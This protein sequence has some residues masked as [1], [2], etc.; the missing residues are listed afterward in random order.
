MDICIK[1]LLCLGQ[2]SN[3]DCNVGVSQVKWIRRDSGLG[4]GP[5]KYQNS[6]LTFTGRVHWMASTEID[7]I[8]MFRSICPGPAPHNAQQLEL[9]HIRLGTFSVLDWTSKLI[10]LLSAP[11]SGLQD[12]I[13]ELLIM[14]KL[15][16]SVETVTDMSAA[17]STDTNCQA[18]QDTSYSS[19]VLGK[20]N[21]INVEN[22]PG[23]LK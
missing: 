12:H 22:P 8:I 21:L 6:V 3:V 9:Y 19:P 11:G 2:G 5:V 16:T 14:F 17:T 20:F 23:H 7:I 4:A 18:T 15:M 1:Y 10:C 13:I